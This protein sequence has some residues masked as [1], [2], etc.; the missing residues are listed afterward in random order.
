MQFKDHNNDLYQIKLKDTEQHKLF[1][2]E[3]IA[4]I[5]RGIITI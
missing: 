4:N 2:H 5:I 3:K 1:N